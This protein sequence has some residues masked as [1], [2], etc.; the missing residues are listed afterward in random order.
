MELTRR[1]FLGLF[2][3]AIAV[4]AATPVAMRLADA[5]PLAPLAASRV[6]LQLRPKPKLIEGVEIISWQLD[7]ERQYT[8]QNFIGGGAEIMTGN[9]LAH[10]DVRAYF[11]A[12][13]MANKF[14]EE[15]DLLI[16]GSGYP[17]LDGKWKMVQYSLVD[18]ASMCA[19]QDMHFIR[20][21]DPR[22]DALRGRSR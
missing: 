22:F 13:L 7:C 16:D 10:L 4:A 21:Y 17:G 14:L 5:A 2:G 19:V 18:G 12:P 6:P 20:L 1:G 8:V 3:K 15:E 9:R 11:D